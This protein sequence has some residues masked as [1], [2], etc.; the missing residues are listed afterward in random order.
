LDH[1][2]HGVKEKQMGKSKDFCNA[3][4]PH[5]KWIMTAILSDSFR[6]T[7]FFHPPLAKC[8]IL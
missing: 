6:E 2:I 5:G 7:D 4:Q 8:Q 3:R 1:H